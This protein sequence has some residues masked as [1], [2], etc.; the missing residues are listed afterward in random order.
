MTAIIELND[1]NTIEP[2]IIFAT[3]EMADSPLGLN[4]S[5]SGLQL[6]WVAKKGYANDWA[7]YAHF[8]I[9]SVEFVADHGDKVCSERNIKTCVPCSED[10]FKQYRY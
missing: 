5:N 1:F 10:M 4:L 9:N 8:A 3:G 6:R 7:I 2:G